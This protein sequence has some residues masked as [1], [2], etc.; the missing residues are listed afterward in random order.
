MREKY[1]IKLEDNEVK[2]KENLQNKIDIRTTKIVL[3]Y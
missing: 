2:F 1:I 3:F